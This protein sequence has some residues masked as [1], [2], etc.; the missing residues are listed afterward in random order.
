MIFCFHKNL[1]SDPKS[2]IRFIINDQ[3]T[4]SLRNTMYYHNGKYKCSLLHFPFPMRFAQ[5]FCILTNLTMLSASLLM[6]WEITDC[7]SYQVEYRK[8]LYS[9][10]KIKLKYTMDPDSILP[11]ILHNCACVI[12]AVLTNLLLS[13]P[14][15]DVPKSFQCIRKVTWTTYRLFESF[16]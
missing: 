11:F 9:F 13:Q 12:A 15:S 10:K 6:L 2:F 8:C 1:K 16:W 5:Y 7:Q 3:S 14:Y 4:Q